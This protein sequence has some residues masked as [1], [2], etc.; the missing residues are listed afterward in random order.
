M[1][2]P[3]W[4]RS[5][6]YCVAY[7]SGGRGDE[8]IVRGSTAC[9]VTHSTLFVPL[10]GLTRRPRLVYPLYLNRCRAV[11]CGL[12]TYYAASVDCHRSSLGSKPFHR[13][14]RTDSRDAQQPSKRMRCVDC[15]R[16]SLGSKPFHRYNRT[17]SKDA[18]Q[19]PKR[20]RRLRAKEPEEAVQPLPLDDVAPNFGRIGSLGLRFYSCCFVV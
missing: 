1:S 11:P 8:A 19:P 14:N 5:H 15:H 13:H 7:I 2:C 18:Q 6:Y 12:A 20:P 17:D 16:F 9:I 3:S 4:S 10:I